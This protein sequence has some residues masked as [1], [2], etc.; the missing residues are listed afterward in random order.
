MDKR[1]YTPKEV[2]AILDVSPDTVIRLIQAERLAGLRVS[3]RLYRI[4]AP[5]FERFVSG[6]Q[7]K[8]RRIVRRSVEAPVAVGE[9]V[10]TPERV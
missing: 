6:R 4:P 5:A 3:D 10:P 8:R 2:A 9:P 7:V 1:Y